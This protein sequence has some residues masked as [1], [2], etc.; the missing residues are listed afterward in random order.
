MAQIFVTGG[1]G[2]IGR[3]LIR[4]L[5][6]EGHDVRALVRSATAADTVT[7]LGAEPVRGVLTEPDTWRHAVSGSE[8][9]FHLAAETDLDAGLARHR[10]VTVDGTRAALQV[11]RDAKVARFVNCG[12]EA[13]LLAGDP[14]IDVDET[15]PLRPDSPAPYC[16][17]KAQ[18]EAIVLDANTHDFTTVSIRP[19]Y[20][21]G[22]GSPV[23]DGF[24]A[25]AKAGQFSWIDGGRHTTD[26]TFVDNA[27]EG[28]LL[29][30]QHGN[31]GEAYFVTDQ[32]PVQ[33]R[34]FMQTVF[35]IYGVDTPIP[36]IDLDTA[37]QSVPVP[38]RWFIG[39]TC[40]LRTDKAV[41]DLGYRPVVSRTAALDILRRSRQS[42]TASAD[43]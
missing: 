7:A 10:L 27:V 6:D 35:D 15:A 22:P 37:T 39:Q 42:E 24:A 12:S 19:K 11:A 18:Q 21:W 9:L 16:A 29:G 31:P 38:A 13:A 36:D 8:V 41:K 20:V 2:F 43:R 26:I 25:L 32:E 28:L 23:T 40:T 14:L 17:V 4:R 30:W 1:S 5:V 33:Y 34:E 3:V